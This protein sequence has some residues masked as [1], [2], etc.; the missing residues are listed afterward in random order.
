MSIGK[1]TDTG[2]GFNRHFDLGSFDP[3]LPARALQT[4]CGYYG[5]ADDCRALACSG[6]GPPEFNPKS[7]GM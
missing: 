4:G 7:Q 6:Q 3:G 2:I 5:A 1:V